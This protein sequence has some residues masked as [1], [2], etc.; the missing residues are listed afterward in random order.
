MASDDNK[1]ILNIQFQISSN[2]KDFPF[3]ENFKIIEKK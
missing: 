2:S 3:S 1:I